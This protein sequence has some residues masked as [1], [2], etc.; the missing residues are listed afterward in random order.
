MFGDAPGSTRGRRSRG[1]AEMGVVRER[2]AASAA[3]AVEVSQ[4]GAMT[5][6]VR[7]RSLAGEA[8]NVDSSREAE[9]ATSGN[10]VTTKGM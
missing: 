7:M 3:S 4:P 6:V 2:T 1:L 10:G 5:S 8:K 9:G